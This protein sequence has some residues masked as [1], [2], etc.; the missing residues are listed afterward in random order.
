[1]VKKLSIFSSFYA[2]TCSLYCINMCNRN[3]V[4]GAGVVD[5]RCSMRETCETTLLHAWV[6]SP[7][8]TV[9]CISSCIFIY[10]TKWP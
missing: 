2:S 9:S 3:C 7:I 10:S 5:T 8:C 1:M 4:Y 6:Q